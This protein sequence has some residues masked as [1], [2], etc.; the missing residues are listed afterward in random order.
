MALDIASLRRGGIIKFVRSA[1]TMK[2]VVFVN[3][4]EIGGRGV[5]LLIGGLAMNLRSQ[6]VVSHSGDPM[7]VIF[8]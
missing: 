6:K 4:M 3:A 8:E 2:V 5:D 1:I 7:V